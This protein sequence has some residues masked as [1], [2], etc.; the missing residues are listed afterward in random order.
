MQTGR[1]IDADTDADKCILHCIV[2]QNG[3]EPDREEKVREGRE[4]EGGECVCEGG[5]V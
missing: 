3:R 5:S 2:Y 1:Q 4:T